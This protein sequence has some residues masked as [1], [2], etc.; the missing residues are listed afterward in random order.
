MAEA[1]VIDVVGEVDELGNEPEFIGRLRA[2]RL[3]A[4]A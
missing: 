2:H 1:G 3:T 4:Q